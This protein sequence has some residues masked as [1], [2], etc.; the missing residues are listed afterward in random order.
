M[1]R[2][3]ILIRLHYENAPTRCQN[4]KE[5]KDMKYILMMT[6][7]KA[8]F[9][10][11]TKWSKQDLQAHT[12]FMHAFNKEL[13]ESGTLVAAEGLAFPDQA[14]IVRA[15][16]NGEPITDGVFPEAKEFLAGYWIVDGESPEQA[17]RIG[18]RAWAAPPPPRRGPGG[19]SENQPIEVRQV[20]SGPPDEM[21]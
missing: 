20:M 6:G 3:R 21:Q 11:Y 15:G 10:W 12:A 16:S 13:K 14:K 8:D 4:R 18:A 1:S 5:Q 9:D 17:Y 19:T 7:T 2:T